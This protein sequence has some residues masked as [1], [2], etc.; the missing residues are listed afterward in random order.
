MPNSKER[1]QK[2]IGRNQKERP[3]AYRQ[4]SFVGKLYEFEKTVSGQKY[5]FFRATF[6]SPDGQ[7][8]KRDCG[9]REKAEAIL[10]DAAAAFGTHRP[11]VLE[12]TPKD[13]RDLDA[14]QSILAPFGLSLYEAAMRLKEALEILPKGASLTEACRFYAAQN[15]AAATPRL[16]AEVLKDLIADRQSSGCSQEHLRDFDKRL[17]PFAE[18]FACTIGSIHPTAVRE[19]LTNLRGAKGQLLSPR[20]RENSR[21][22]IT[23]LFNFASQQRLIGKD[24]AQEI[25]EIPPP[26]IRPTPTTTF[27]PAEIKTILDAATKSDRALIAIGGFAGLRTAELHRLDWRNVHLDEGHITVDAGISKTASRRII[28]IAPNLAEWLRPLAQT[29]GHISRHAHEHRLA[30]SFCKIAAAAGVTW[31]RNALRHSFVTYRLAQVR[32]APQVALE[33]GHTVTVLH[34]NY[35]ELATAAQAVAWFNVMPCEERQTRKPT[36]SAR[37]SVTA[38]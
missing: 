37:V 28:P 21:R 3:T 9:T 13:R 2:V 19:Y 23:A 36:K 5:K 34:A 26:K 6:H 20:S 35:A 38:V 33:A 32:N 11:D 10:H 24:L 16:V 30:W 15:L 31:Q 22:L 7:L 18:A 1:T 4:G 17:R 25:A 12:I 14:A 8:T 27:T 29:S